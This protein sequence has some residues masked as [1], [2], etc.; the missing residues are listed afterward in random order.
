MDRQLQEKEAIVAKPPRGERSVKL[1]IF[2]RTWGK[3][4]GYQMLEQPLSKRITMMKKTIAQELAPIYNRDWR[5]P[6]EPKMSEK[7]LV[8][9]VSLEE[10]MYRFRR[11]VLEYRFN[12]STRS[13]EAAVT[14]E[15][16]GHE[17]KAKPEITYEVVGGIGHEEDRLLRASIR[18]KQANTSARK[19]EASYAREASSA[20]R[21]RRWDARRQSRQSR[22]RA[23]P[24]YSRPRRPAYGSGFRMEDVET[25]NGGMSLL[26]AKKL[27]RASGIDWNKVDFTVEAFKEGVEVE[28]K[29]HAD[30]TKGNLGK[31]AKIAIAHLKEDPEYYEKLERMEKGGCD[32]DD[33][34]ED[35][36]KPKK[37]I[38]GAMRR[39]IIA[40]IKNKPNPSDDDFHDMA[41]KLGLHPSQ[42]EELVYKIAHTLMKKK[43]EAIN[44]AT[45]L[46]AQASAQ[47]KGLPG[48]VQ[49]P[50]SKA[51]KKK[52]VTGGQS[53]MNETKVVHL[54]MLPDARDPQFTAVW[55]N[56]GGR[57][58]QLERIHNTGLGNI[59]GMKTV[60]SAV[61][62]RI[63]EKMGIEKNNFV[64][65][66]NMSFKFRMPDEV[67]QM[68]HEAMDRVGLH[69][70]GATDDDPKFIAQDLEHSRAPYV[71]TEGA[72][73]NTLS[74]SLQSILAGTGFDALPR[75][76]YKNILA[77]TSSI[78][79]D[80]IKRRG[81]NPNSPNTLQAYKRIA[82]LPRL[83][84]KITNISTALKYV[85]DNYEAALHAAAS[86]IADLIIRELALGAG[87]R[88]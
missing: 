5:Q 41:E 14:Y 68:I 40:F 2:R 45:R 33:D 1:G 84:V 3:L 71:L 73:T 72:G 60:F 54:E 57:R 42:A 48:S 28:R 29:E 88:H 47:K 67:K 22:R 32:E 18:E 36:G 44:I 20:S 82:V 52:R 65:F 56:D 10:A 13:V 51:K 53:H 38:T 59:D 61:K 4:W 9:Y 16:S 24:I 66:G 8:R 83:K 49:K 35:K 79:V 37:K 27:G 76:K 75:P 34:E 12:F 26:Q 7:E 80:S 58:V 25:E 85:T 46:K 78:I 62:Y 31:A 15:I 87:V 64:E 63:N 77:K 39:G 21:E 81:H 50:R 70:H 6:H 17:K 55:G 43:T 23:T 86:K 30:I 74:V 19:A 11:D 69:L